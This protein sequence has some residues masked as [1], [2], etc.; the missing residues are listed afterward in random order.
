[1]D[2]GGVIIRQYRPIAC[3]CIADRSHGLL[4]G[5]YIAGGNV[6]FLGLGGGMGGGGGC[7]RFSPAIEF[8]TYFVES[9][10][11]L[12]PFGITHS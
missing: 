3:H 10:H 2:G 8:R 9:E 7:S 11:F 6:C 12:G 1:M 5:S 4:P